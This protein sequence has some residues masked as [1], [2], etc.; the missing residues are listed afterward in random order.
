[1]NQILQHSRRHSYTGPPSRRFVPVS[2]C[3]VDAL[4]FYLRMYGC[5]TYPGIGTD[6]MNKGCI[7]DRVR[8]INIGKDRAELLANRR[9]IKDDSGLKNSRSGPSASRHEERACLKRYGFRGLLCRGSIRWRRSCG[10]IS[11][12]RDKTSVF[13]DVSIQGI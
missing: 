7:S 12:V 5:T 8:R 2:S 1:M 10:V 9:A 3:S 4:S 11:K 6:E 13:V